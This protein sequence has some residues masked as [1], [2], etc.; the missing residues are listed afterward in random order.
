MGN[1]AGEHTTGSRAGTLQDE[2][3]NAAQRR[4]SDLHYFL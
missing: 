4:F 3:E 1:S 2:Y